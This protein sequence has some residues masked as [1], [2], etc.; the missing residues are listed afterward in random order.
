MVSELQKQKTKQ[1]HLPFMA[2]FTD[3]NIFAEETNMI[4][5]GRGRE[6]KGRR[7]EWSI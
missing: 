1:L 2:Q 5:R 4:V 7:G 3:G 6:M